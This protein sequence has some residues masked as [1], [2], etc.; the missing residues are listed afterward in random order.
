MTNT[1]NSDYESS[2]ACYVQVEKGEY[3][4]KDVPTG[5]YLIQAINENQNLKLHLTP[6]FLEIEV[7]KDTLQLKE[8]FKISGFTVSGQVLRSVGGEPLKGAIVK[9]NGQK[10]GETDATGSYT[11]EN[12]KSGSYSIEILSPQLQFAPL[13]VKAQIS[14]PSLPTIVPS[15]Y[16][17]CGNVVSQ[18]SYVVGIT[19]VGST[20][21]TTATTEPQSGSWCAFLPAGK[22]SFE[23]LTTDT[24]KA[25]G[26]QFFPVQQQSE[27]RDGPLNGITF[28]QLRANIRGEL[29]CLPDATATCTSAEVT[30]QGLDPSGQPTD[31]KWKA[32][33]HRKSRSC[34]DI[35]IAGDINIPH[36]RW[37]ILLQGCVARSLRDYNSTRQP[38]LRVDPCLLERRLR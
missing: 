30:L 13:Q 9:L 17:V 37:K 36:F 31:N 24:D 10:V 4:F 34:I 32:R 26:I 19:K 20:F 6:K 7:G 27:V 2:A 23:V 22:Y 29:Q 18:K 38:V 8:E 16:E 25:S 5:K 35:V 1:L 21:H 28:S 14:T 12:I 15:A 33:A 3:S 11:L